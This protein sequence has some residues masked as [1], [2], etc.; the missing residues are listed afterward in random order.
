MSATRVCTKCFVEKPVEDFGWKNRVLNRRHAVCKPCT[1]KRSNSWYYANKENHIKNVMVRTKEYRQSAREYVWDYL[2]T[3]PCEH[4]GESNPIVL[5]FHH[6]SGKD[7]AIST[8]VARAYA[9][10]SIQAEINRCIVLCAN[11]HRKVT[12]K[13]RGWFAG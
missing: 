12:A 11:C 8:M 4:C 5:E 9:V 10:P 1:A 13:E 6:K 2:S 7:L 3:H